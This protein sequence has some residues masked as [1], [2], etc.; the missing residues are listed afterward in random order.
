MKC[1]TER[2]KEWFFETAFPWLVFGF[3]GL[4]LLYCIGMFLLGVALHIVDVAK[5]MGLL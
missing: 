1:T 3:L 5:G 4:W 2:A